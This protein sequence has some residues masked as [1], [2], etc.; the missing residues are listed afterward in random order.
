METRQD[1]G[2]V[3][4]NRVVDAVGEA[5]EDCSS[6]ACRYNGIALGLVLNSKKDCIRLFQKSESESCLLFFIPGKRLPEYRPVMR[7]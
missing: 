7:V 5:S 2:F 6:Y 4:L 1:D 3:L